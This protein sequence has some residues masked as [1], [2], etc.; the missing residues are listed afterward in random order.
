[1]ECYFYHRHSAILAVYAPMGRLPRG[2]DFMQ[3]SKQFLTEVALKIA[4]A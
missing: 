4:A 3:F 1:V 2:M